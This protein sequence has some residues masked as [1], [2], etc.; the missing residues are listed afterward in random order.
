MIK[1]NLES[2]CKEVHNIVS[3]GRVL[4]VTSINH[5]S[6]LE[7]LCPCFIV[8]THTIH[9]SVS[10]QQ[11]LTHHTVELVVVG[12]GYC[13][14]LH[15]AKLSPLRDLHQLN[16]KHFILLWLQIV[17]NGNADVALGLAMLEGQF[18]LAAGVVL[19]VD[20]G[21]V[22]SPP[23]YYDFA[24]STVLPKLEMVRNSYTLFCYPKV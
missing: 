12:D 20:C 7:L 9:I 23:F 6:I 15:L 14:A 4:Q 22:D 3:S 11:Q 24:V 16:L 13:G 10:H 17:Y 21:F 2:E 5:H 8:N 19:A 1:P 18:T